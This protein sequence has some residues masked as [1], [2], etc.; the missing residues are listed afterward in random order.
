MYL[1]FYS[2]NL[3][4]YRCLGEI[5]GDRFRTLGIVGKGVFS[6]VLKCIDIHEE[7]HLLEELQQQQIMYS[8]PGEKLAG[9]QELLLQ[10]VVLN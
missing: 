4:F 5:I 9:H 2:I 1:L 10:V 6:T 3:S 7:K 8:V